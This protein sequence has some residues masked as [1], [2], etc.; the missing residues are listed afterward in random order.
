MKTDIIYLDNAATAW[1]KPDNVYK[2]MTEFYSRMGVNPGRSGFDKAIEAGNIIENLRKRLT[3]FFGGDEDTPERLCF[4]YNATDALN[5]IINGLLSEGDHVVTTNLEHNS[6]IR[7]I[8]H[9]V[10]DGGVEATYL[11]FDSDGFI[12]PEDVRKAIQPNTRLVIVNHGSNVIGTIQPVAEIGKV[13][14][15]MEVTFAI[16]SSQTAGVVPINM[17][18]MNIDVL[19]FTGHKALMGST[20][21]GGLCVRKHV[22]LKQ[23]RSGG[24][25]VRSAYPYHL[26]EYPWRMEFGTPNMVGIA[27][28]WAGQ[29]WIEQQGGEREI[30]TREM[31][32]ADKFVSALKEI[33]EISLYCCNSLD[34]HLSTVTLNVEGL[35]AGDVGIMLDVD[36]NIATRTGLHCAPLVHEQLGIL[37]IHGG[38]RFSIGAFNTEEHIDSAINALQE[39]STGSTVKKKVIS[40]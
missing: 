39:I 30:H 3:S 9:L 22:E 4:G 16:D 19:A 40:G 10:R 12:D 25:G 14:K 26:E 21:I 29:E 36:H 37:D 15:E 31:E 28:L 33:D 1:P 24:T 34:N 20:G 27:A 35:E 18:E 13:C 7:P 11:P 23:T 5:L 38:V 17:K 8:N 6:V 32:L 2:F